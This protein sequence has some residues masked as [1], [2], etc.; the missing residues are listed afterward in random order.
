M[1]IGPKIEQRR[2]KLGLS[3]R[4]LA[5]RLGVSAQAISLWETGQLNPRKDRIA[6]IAEVLGYPVRTL[7]N[8]FFEES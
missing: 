1:Q 8:S 7:I 6:K 4:E 2:L 5:K 3:Q